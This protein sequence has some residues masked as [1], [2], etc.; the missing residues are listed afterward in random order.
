MLAAWVRFSMSRRPRPTES[1]VESRLIAWL[2]LARR[3]VHDAPTLPTVQVPAVQTPADAGHAQAARRVV[4]VGEVRCGRRRSCAV[5][6]SMRVTSF[7]CPQ[8]AAGQRG[9]RRAV[10]RAATAGG[11]GPS[12]MSCQVV[13]PPTI[14]AGRADRGGDERARS[15][16]T[17]P[18]SSTKLPRPPSAVAGGR[19]ARLAEVGHLGDRVVAGRALVDLRGC[20]G[21]CRDR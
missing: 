13:R 16:A 4:P 17:R 10:V 8:H 21:R 14:G 15:T 9:R 1:A 5:M 12:V 3:C 19:I 2:Q 6:R 7:S 18:S 11:I 20:S